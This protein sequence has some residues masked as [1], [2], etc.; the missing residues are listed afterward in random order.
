[1]LEDGAVGTIVESFASSSGAAEKNVY[2]TNA[3]SEIIVGKD[4]HLDHCK[5]QQEG[6]DAFHVATMQVHLCR[7]A[8]FVSHSASIGASS[9]AMTSM[10]PWPAR[11]PMPRSTAWR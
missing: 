5:L 7:A 9:R 1:M 2:F 4:A 11:A 3:V 6:P 10:S 8:H